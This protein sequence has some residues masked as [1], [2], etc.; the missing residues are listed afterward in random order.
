MLV[1]S[2]LIESLKLFCD[3]LKRIFVV[4]DASEIVLMNIEAM[5]WKP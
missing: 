4:R 5:S 1:K 3:S 2:E